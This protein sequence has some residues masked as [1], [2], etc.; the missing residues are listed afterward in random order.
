MLLLHVLVSS[1]SSRL[2]Y[3]ALIISHV[4]FFIFSCLELIVVVSIT[5]N[6]MNYEV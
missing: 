2:F 1:C 6:C 4:F 5:S 3:L